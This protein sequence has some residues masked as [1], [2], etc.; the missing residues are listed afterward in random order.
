MFFLILFNII[1]DYLV[2]KLYVFL[3]DGSCDFSLM[4]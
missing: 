4:F 2:D 1:A 3:I